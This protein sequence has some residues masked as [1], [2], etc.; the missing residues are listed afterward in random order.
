[1]GE[2]PRWDGAPATA[3]DQTTWQF[4]GPLPEA[5]VEFVQD[6]SEG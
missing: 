4:R 1:M 5:H 6:G 2:L 3:F